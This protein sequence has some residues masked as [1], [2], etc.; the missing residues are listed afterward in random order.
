MRRVVNL[1]RLNNRF[2]WWQSK[3]RF[4]FW[5]W[6]LAGLV[7]VLMGISQWPPCLSLG[8]V[9]GLALF[10]AFLISGTLFAIVRPVMIRHYERQIAN[11]SS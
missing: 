5:G 2:N 8:N 3:P 4:P 9:I 6:S 10:G 11:Y 1:N 7:G